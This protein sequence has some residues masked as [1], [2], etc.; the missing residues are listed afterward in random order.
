M[1]AILSI[2]GSVLALVLVLALVRRH[3]P[4]FK[5]RLSSA[6]VALMLERIVEGRPWVWS[7]FIDTPIEDPELEKIR[8]RVE[9]LESSHPPG[10]KDYYLN[11][12]GRT[13]LRSIISE[14][15]SIE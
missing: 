12:D 11:E 3:L 15:R 10:P 9:K 13:I 7:D 14:L 4:P 5:A 6:D 8:I 1:T 2:I